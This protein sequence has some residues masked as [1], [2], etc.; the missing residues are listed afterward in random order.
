MSTVEVRRSSLTVCALAMII[1]SANVWW[2]SA[3]SHA[4]EATPAASRMTAASTS[5]SL[6]GPM[7][8]TAPH[9]VISTADQEPYGPLG[10]R[11][12]KSRIVVGIL[13]HVSKPALLHPEIATKR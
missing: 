2:T 9:L 13:R 11:E 1:V 3:D 8:D 4:Q 12:R 5:W 10:L 6:E 7:S